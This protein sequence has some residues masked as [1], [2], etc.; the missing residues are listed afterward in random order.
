MMSR[1]RLGVVDV[2]R[3]WLKGSVW[4][5]GPSG[6]LRTWSTVEVAHHESVEEDSRLVDSIRCVISDVRRRADVVVAFSASLARSGR[7]DPLR[8][9]LVTLA[10]HAFELSPVEEARLLATAACGC[11]SIGTFALDI[12]GGSV[13][14][15]P[16]DPTE[17][18]MSWPVGTVSVER[19]FGLPQGSP[20]ELYLAVS[21]QLGREVEICGTTS[22]DRLLIGSNA[23][24]SL[25][26]SIAVRIGKNVDTS[27]TLDDLDTAWRYC[28]QL[29]RPEFERVFPENPSMLLGADKAML[30][31]WIVCGKLL[32]RRIEGTNASVAEG[33][34][35][36]WFASLDEG[37]NKSSL[38]SMRQ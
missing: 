37:N 16:C 32:P 18:T 35:S 36:R 38:P 27:W 26:N 24:R 5:Q 12:G 28:A 19:K 20:I 2:G 4:R 30:I 10:D 23:M 34:A 29:P 9:E 21:A 6:P 22:C 8:K 15:C 33:V 1:V 3:A 13:Q 25:M 11:G 31:A 7:M 17:P 14:L